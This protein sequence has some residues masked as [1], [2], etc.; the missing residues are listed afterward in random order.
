M[1]YVFLL[2]CLL[3]GMA[4]PLNGYPYNAG[5]SIVGAHCNNCPLPDTP[6]TF[7]LKPTVLQGH[8][9]KINAGDTMLLAALKGVKTAAE[10]ILKHPAYSVMLKRKTPP[11]GDKHDYMSV[12][13]YWWPDSTKPDGLPY[14]RRDGQVN[15]E[16]FGIQDAEYY[17][18]LCKDVYTLGIAWYFTHDPRYAAHA[19]KLV[20]TWFLDPATRMNPHLNYAQAI[21]GITAGRGIGVIDTHNTPLLLDGLQLLKAAPELTAADYIGVQSW[22][23]RFLDWMRTSPI[24]L[25]EADELNNHGTWYDVQAVGIALFTGQP[26]LARQIIEQDTKRRI[27]SQLQPDGR[28]PLELARTLS[29]NYSQMNL[30]G[31]QQLALLAENVNIDLWHYQSPGKK[32][33]EQAFLWMLP[34]ATGQ[35]HWT[36]QQI[37]P[38]D[39]SGYL[40][41]AMTA[42]S[43]YPYVDLSALWQQH[44]YVPGDLY[45][46]T[47][48]LD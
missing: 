38:M 44:P 14:I 16:R 33:L 23:R 42:H 18:A 31:F 46:L 12:G 45:R 40:E 30:Q 47:H 21:P 36:Y 28:Q 41:L 27:D 6:Q 32:S 19:V 17:T 35:K 24:G 39:P 13:P 25:D 2:C 9:N 3:A 4:T 20:R 1:K 26:A 8:L 48:S 37:K 43:H 22:Y 29:W 15:P 34:F 11:S 10:G 7:L 5:R